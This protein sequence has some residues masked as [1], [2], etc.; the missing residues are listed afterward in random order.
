MMHGAVLTPMLMATV[1]S[2]VA[3][4]VAIFVHPTPLSVM[5]LGHLQIYS[6]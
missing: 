4:V 1:L 2:A 3:E 5:L 6:L